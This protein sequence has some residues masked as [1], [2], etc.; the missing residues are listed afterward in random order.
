MIASVQA[1]SLFS[2]ARQHAASRS[3]ANLV[4]EHLLLAVKDIEKGTD[5]SVIK[6]FDHI[7]VDIAKMCDLV[8]ERLPSGRSKA[9]VDEI[10][11]SDGL[12]VELAIARQ[13]GLQFG[14]T[15]LD[16]GDLLLAM[17][18]E[19]GDRELE[20]LGVTYDAVRT[21]AEQHLSA[22][23][24]LEYPLIDEIALTAGSAHVLEY[25]RVLARQ[26]GSKRVGTHHVLM[27]L[28]VEHGP[29]RA[30]LAQ[31]GVTYEKV[32]G[33]IESQKAAEGSD[34]WLDS[35]WRYRAEMTRKAG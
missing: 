3:H 24:P 23:M 4:R 5:A 32:R 30:A 21:L 1:S 16:T 29:L 31:R 15:F 22:E 34:G 26:D 33:W 7:G 2:Y 9:S 10:G 13:F 14:R 20:T 11:T 28:L 12:R 27:A 6:F 18:W 35:P 25:A 19:G 8:G 17:L